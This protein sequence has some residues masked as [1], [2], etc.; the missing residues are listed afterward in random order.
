MAPLPAPAKSSKVHAYALRLP[1]PVKT[2]NKLSDQD[3]DSVHQQFTMLVDSLLKDRSHVVPLFSALTSRVSDSSA[4]P[5][6]HG[7]DSFS[8][9][10]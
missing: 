6:S 7:A 1:K 9:H 5:I 4:V 2:G 8:K 3:A 10:P